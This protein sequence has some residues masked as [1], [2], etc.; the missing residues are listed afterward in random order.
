MVLALPQTTRAQLSPGDL[1]QSHAFLEGV[2]NCN[3]CHGTDAH[4]IA[5]KCLECHSLIRDRLNARTG[6]HGS[7][8]YRECQLCHVEHQGR[9]FDL[10]CW[11]NGH[12][13][14][15]HAH[16]GYALDGKHASLECRACHRETYIP[17]RSALARDKITL[18]RT[19]LGLDKACKSCHFDEHRGQVS[20]DCANCHTTAAWKPASGFD[21]SLAGY[22]L[23]GKHLEVACDKCHLV[24]VDSRPEDDGRYM[25]L[26]PIAHDLCTDCHFDVHKG[27]LGSNCRNCHNPDGW[28]VTD[29]AKFDHS[30]TRFPL[31]GRHASVTCDKCHA[32]E[33][34]SRELKFGA[35]LDC[36]SD[37]HRGEF[38][39]RPAKGACEEC[40]TVAGYSPATFLMSQHES[41]QYPLRGAHRA[42][43]C[44]ACHTSRDGEQKALVYHF[45]FRSTRC[46]D[47]HRDP[48][49]GEVN[50]YVAA[51]G[52][53]T[54]HGVEYWALVSF[55]H[56]QTRFALD[57]KHAAVA[58]IMCHSTGTPARGETHLT[59]V[60]AS[61]QCQDCH[62]DVH[63]S[64]FAA[65]LT[66]LTDCSGCHTSR[67][68]KAEK[69]DH[70]RGSRFALDGAHRH[71]ACGRCH[72]PAMVDG[73]R[74]VAY[75]PLDT[76]CVSCHGAN[77]SLESEKKS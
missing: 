73:E 18:S 29:R 5:N 55:D 7:Q 44:L 30:R 15:N 21:H 14:F 69:F 35:C 10:V 52:C 20:T 41:T 43:P 57:G 17:D 12:E 65:S 27:K 66:H 70:N 36:H 3:R 77:L 56:S 47:C 48:H 9:D 63:R 39:S 23:L 49:R 61:K 33:K 8:N 67:N 34:K 11:K 31:L 68:W 38:A 50:K 53:E 51:G 60:G 6:L 28:H 37:F 19:Y 75:K 72:V 74:F 42:V 22:A 40:H 62:R 4:L 1:H 45:K 76:A 25:H 2:Q 58:C 13:G 71:V 64:Q 46:L 24:Q 16:T 26:R 54:C 32:P 59:F